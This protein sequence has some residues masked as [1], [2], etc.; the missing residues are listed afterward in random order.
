VE[1]T[2]LLQIARTEGDAEDRMDGGVAKTIVGEAN[3]I[4]SASVIRLLNPRVWRMNRICP[5]TSPFG[6][7]L[8]WP[9]PD[10]VHNLVTLYRSPCSIERPKSLA[11]IFPPFDRSM[12]LFHNII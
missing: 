3:K 11:G 8:T 9:F 2:V 4:C 12:I 7:H 6:S 5:I 10:H 1:R